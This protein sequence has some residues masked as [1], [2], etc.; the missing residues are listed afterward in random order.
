MRRLPNGLID[1][2]G[3]ATP[4]DP[5]SQIILSNKVPPKPM[6]PAKFKGLIKKLDDLGKLDLE[7]FNT[8]DEMCRFI[9]FYNTTVL[10]NKQ[11]AYEKEITARNEYYWKL[12]I[13]AVDEAR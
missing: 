12:W 4:R 2:G 8:V 5:K 1:L 3:G 6:N 7:D 9:D 10:E 11:S 13:R